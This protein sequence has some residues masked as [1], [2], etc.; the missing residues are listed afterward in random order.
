MVAWYAANQFIH[1]ITSKSPMS[2]SIRSIMGGTESIPW[3]RNRMLLEKNWVT[4]WWHLVVWWGT[5]L[6]YGGARWYDG[7]TGLYRDNTKSSRCRGGSYCGSGGGSDSSFLPFLAC[8]AE[9]SLTNISKSRSTSSRSNPSWAALFSRGP[10][11]LMSLYLF[12][13]TKKGWAM[14]RIECFFKYLCKKWFRGT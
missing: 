12:F 9:M 14:V 13:F 8:W 10:P 7:G 6:Y 4:L 2:T 3:K 1:R 11:L 5:R